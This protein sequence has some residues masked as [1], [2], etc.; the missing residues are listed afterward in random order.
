MGR[1]VLIDGQG[2]QIDYKNGKGPAEREIEKQ[3]R[4]VEQGVGFIEDV[5]EWKVEHDNAHNEEND[6]G[7]TQLQAVQYSVADTFDHCASLR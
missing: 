3:Q 6:P 5:Q 4:K 1:T 2:K 7:F